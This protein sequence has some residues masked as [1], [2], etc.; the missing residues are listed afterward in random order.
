MAPAATLEKT[1]NSNT[2]MLLLRLKD[3]NHEAPVFQNAPKIVPLTVMV[4]S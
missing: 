1:A 2:S 4:Y 3:E